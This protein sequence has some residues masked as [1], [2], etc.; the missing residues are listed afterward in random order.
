MTVFESA[1]ET[2]EVKKLIENGDSSPENMTR[3]E[4]NLKDTRYVQNI[5]VLF[6]VLSAGTDS[7]HKT[8]VFFHSL[9]NLIILMK[10]VD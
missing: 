10:T 9:C 5:A 4:M 2:L 1:E 7:G 6:Y 8:L 3:F